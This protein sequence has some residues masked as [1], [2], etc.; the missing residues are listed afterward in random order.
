MTAALWYLS[1]NQW[2][3]A[4]G[5]AYSGATCTFYVGSTTT[6]LSVYADDA[7]TTPLGSTIT[8]DAN[9]TFP[10]CFIPV[11]GANYGFV[12]KS[13]AGV[14]LFAV[15]SAN[16]GPANSSGGGGGTVDPTTIFQTGDEL[17]I[18]YSG[19]RAGWV[20]ANGRTIGSA[21]SGATERANSDTS[22]LY[23]YLWNNFADA[24]CPVSTGRGASAAADFAANKTI[25]T[26]D[27]RGT[28]IMGLDDM[29]NSA[30]SRLTSVP[31]VSGAGVTTPGA[32]VGENLHALAT[33]ELASHSH[34]GTTDSGGTH[35][36]T[37][38]ATNV[39]S[40][41]AGGGNGVWNNGTGRSTDSGGAH[42]HTFTTDTSGS[43]T[44]HNT[45][46]RSALKTCYLKL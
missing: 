28:G 17:W 39:S 46:Q 31:V 32:I 20:R 21:S 36:H 15:T 34:T 30:A 29:G 14:Q 1:G 13:A 24:L 33:G 42:T 23:T 2:R 7:L 25:G 38:P 11:T 18:S 22:A 9:G 4:N 44:A 8:A 43:G 12:I 26:P 19:T 35:S 37:I 40:V 3:D 27:W 45:V 10:A 6:P 5:A 41:G 16:P